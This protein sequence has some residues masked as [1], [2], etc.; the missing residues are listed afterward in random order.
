MLKAEPTAHGLVAD[1][2]LREQTASL[3]LVLPT[4]QESANIETILR[5]VIAV[6]DVLRIPY[7]LI[8]VDDA[9]NDGTAAIVAGL[10][11][12][13]PQIRLVERHGERGLSG[14]ILD[15]WA[16][17][18]ATVVGVIDADL[19]HPPEIL[20][21]LWTAMQTGVD[22]AVASRYARG[23]TIGRWRWLRRN[24]S[25][26]AVLLCRPLQRRNCLVEDPMSGFFMIRR[27][28][29]R[30]LPPLQRS[31]FK[32]LLE[33]LVRAPLRK[34]QEVPFCF[35]ERYG[36]ESKADFTVMRDY[37]VLLARLYWSRLLH[38]SAARQDTA[39]RLGES[40]SEM[41]HPL[42]S[43]SKPKS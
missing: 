7:E 18:S 30:A 14:A 29:V 27:S 26:G 10:S 2:P 28:I 8:V 16:T 19:Q 35:G 9:S 32:L 33:I 11:T 3:A 40:A 34:V 22:L 42:L 6:L 20:P 12:A 1:T 37:I 15:G 43:E 31:G 36:G 25:T 39:L 41:G 17:A 21:K 38:R 24:I 4:L 23:A 13:F 5:R